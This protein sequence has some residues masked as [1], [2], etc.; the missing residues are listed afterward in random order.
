LADRT[1]LF[2][3]KED[4]VASSKSVVK[5]TLLMTGWLCVGLGTIGAFVLLLPTTPFLL[6]ADFFFMRSSPRAH[7]WLTTNRLLG[8]YLTNYLQHRVMTRRHKT[9][10][11]LLL[12][13]VA[14]VSVV[15]AGHWHV[16]VVLG[17]VCVGVTVHIVLL[18]GR[19]KRRWL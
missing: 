4:V 6:L 7:R 2:D 15:L 8:P 12:W 13:G 16:A 3:V 10:S 11:L 1:V 17:V 5:V 9:V 18:P 14:G 19:Q